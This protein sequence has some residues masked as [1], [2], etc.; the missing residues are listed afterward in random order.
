MAVPYAFVTLLTSDHYLPGALTLAAALKDLHPRPVGHADFEYQLVCLVTPESVD[1]STIKF[2]RR[3]FDVVVGVELI[4]LENDTNLKLLGERPLSILQLLQRRQ[5]CYMR[6]IDARTRQL[7]TVP[8]INDLIIDSSV[9]GDGVNPGVLTR[10]SYVLPIRPLSHLFTLPHEFS[11]VPD[12][13]WPDIFN[14]G[15]LVFSPGE[16]KF[17]E[18]INL[19]KAKGSWDGGDQGIL[20][21]WRGSNWNRLSFTYNTTPTAAYTYAPAYARYGSQISAIHFIGPNKPW[22]S[23][24]DR[25]PF[26]QGSSSTNADQAYHYDA[27]VD[28]WFSVYDA[29]YRSSS[30]PAPEQP[31]FEVKRYVSAWNEAKHATGHHGSPLGLDE[32]KRLAIEG[33]SAHAL[34]AERKP[35]EGEYKSFPLGG[36]IALL[37]QRYNQRSDSSQGD[38]DSDQYGLP[39]LPL[40]PSQWLHGPKTPGLYDVPPGPHLHTV[41]LP[42]TPTPLPGGSPTGAHTS[43]SQRSRRKSQRAPH[44]TESTPTQGPPASPQ[45]YFALSRGNGHSNPHL[46]VPGPTVNPAALFRSP[47]PLESPTRYQNVAGDFE[48]LSPDRNK[49]KSVFPWEEKPRQLGRVFPSSDTPSLSPFL[50]P[51]SQSSAI[52]PSTPENQIPRSVSLLSPLHGISTSI[53][54]ANAWDVVPSIQQYASKLVKPSARAPGL[55]PVPDND[56]WQKVDR[57]KSW[58]ERLEVDSRDG[59]VEDEVD[60]E[61]G[62]DIQKKRKEPP[63]G[64]TRTQKEYISRGVQTDLRELSEQAVQVISTEPK[65]VDPGTPLLLP[66]I[67][68]NN[69]P[70]YRNHAASYRSRSVAVSQSAR[71][72]RESSYSPSVKGSLNG[73][74][75]NTQPPLVTRQ[76]S[77]DSSVGSPSSSVGPQSPSDG[78][79]AVSPLRK[80]GRVWDPARGVD[81]FKRG[82]EEVL[83]RFLKMSSWEEEAT[84]IA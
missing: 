2:L 6:L 60:D 17:S 15:V 65:T 53:S 58:D 69:S 47:V 67:S 84:R 39:N 80:G 41:P 70:I 22:K 34:S 7:S 18:L 16:E 54:Y 32:L 1:V 21:E 19:L 59:D 29:H 68:L 9:P 11:A 62:S 72:S 76:V 82:S 33:A 4:E 5:S 56:D 75:K 77:N 52:A 10:S 61:D 37:R 36:R 31:E 71:I 46:S 49:V 38:S 63:K 44:S 23:L 3:A 66:S 26:V 81:L 40:P 73:K 27:L 55:D 57:Y 12:V 74:S 43:H 79:L 48:H 35:G 14:S 13:G 50:S 25:L 51:G 45:S 20:N 24:S 8:V 28:R 30:T 78:N 42:Y 64:P 83:A